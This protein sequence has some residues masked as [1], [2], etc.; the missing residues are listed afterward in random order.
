LRVTGTLACSGTLLV[1]N[2][3][4]TLAVGDSFKIFNAAAYSGNFTSYR[5]PTLGVGLGWNTTNLTVNGTLSVIVTASPQFSS[6]VQRS[7]GNFQFSGT[8]AA[9]VTNEL[10]VANNLLSPIA[11][12]FV[13][14]AVADQSGLFQF[15]DLQA[16]NFSQRFYRIMAGQ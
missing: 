7:D 13:T 1:T 6:I 10:D 3:S 12:L 15:V 14:N 5:L 16:T 2:L 8:G 4:G 9:G 11:W